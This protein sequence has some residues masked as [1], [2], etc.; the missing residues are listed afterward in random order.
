MKFYLD[1]ANVEQVAEVASWGILDGVTTNPSLVAKEGKDF[2]KTV[3]AM[4]KYAKSVSAQVTA[5]DSKE[6]IKQGLQYASWH[7]NV[8]VKVP[9]T[10]EGLKALKAL[11]AKKIRTNTT[12]VFSVEQ[13]IMAA[14][15]GATMVSPFVG[16]LDDKGEDG[17][18]VI[19]D[20]VTAFKNY[21]I[22]TEV[23][24]ASVRNVAHVHR[25]LLLGAHIATMPYSVMVE[26][27]KH[28]LT[29]A[30]L[31]KFMDDWKSV[32]K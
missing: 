8:V 18:K 15:A 25:A 6:M 13:A 10:V 29:D 3:L 20:I 14:K 5:E 21:G 23:L 27:P 12:L 32:K 9:M 24:V 4:C 16:R 11:S 22:K 2:K 30:G 7:K 17:M 1:T 26:L 19:E 28:S 31:K